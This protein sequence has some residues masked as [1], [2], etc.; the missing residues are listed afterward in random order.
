VLVPF[1]E[2]FANTDAALV[3]VVIVV[4]IA[5]IGYRL[6]GVAAAVSTAATFDFFL[7]RPYEQ[8]TISSATDVETAALLLVVGFAVTELAVWGRRQQAM[9]SRDAGYLAGIQAASE[10]M[11][12]GGSGDLLIQEVSSQLTR[13]LGLGG[14]RFQRGLAG[15][16]QPPRLRRDGEVVWDR[17]VWDVDHD[18]L[19]TDAEIELLVE[20]GGRL[21]GRFLLTATPQSRHSLADRRTAVTLADQ[22]GAALG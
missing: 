2:S 17:K 4:A 1:R 14:C 11:A 5:A 22:V 3:F 19:P 13:A 12:T 7:T 20:N 6:A 9:A 10:V 21:H 18:G 16:G 8:F 15:V